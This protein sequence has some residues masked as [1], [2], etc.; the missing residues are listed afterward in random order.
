[1]KVYEKEIDGKTVRKPKNEI[2]I[3]KGSK[4]IINPTEGQLLEEGWG[5]YLPVIPEQKEPSEEER[6]E[7]KRQEVLQKIEEHDAS[8][9]VNRCRITIGGKEVSYWAGKM[10]RSSLKTAVEDY[11]KM[12][13]GTYRLDLRE[14]GVSV[15]VDCL[16]LLEMLSALEVYAIDCYNKT[17]DHIF[18]VRR[19]ES[20]EELE[21]YRYEEDYPGMLT[22]NL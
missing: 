20:V 22:F 5:L 19:L 10:E 15:S 2:V 11:M 4:Q 6:L 13:R 21:A 3:L 16:L 18:N 12:G 1:M 14:V 17:T 8:E 9:K 7:T